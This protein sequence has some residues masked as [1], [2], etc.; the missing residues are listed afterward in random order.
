M[1]GRARSELSGWWH[2]G[3][4]LV[5][6][7]LRVCFRYRVVGIEGVPARGPAILA[8]NHVSALDGPFL[9]LA[10]GRKRKRMTRFLVAAEF[11]EHPQF[12]RALRLLQQIPL[13]R[14]ARDMGALE[15]AERTI[16]AGAL[17]G[18]FPE[19]RVNP[20]PDAGLQRGRRGMAIIALKSRAAIV[21]VG[22]W[23]TQDRWPRDGLHFRRP[24]RPRVALVFGEPI[25]PPG[26][27][28]SR[29]DLNAFTHLVMTRIE[30][31]VE[32]ARAIIRSSR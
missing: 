30:S 12:G 9:A 14:G 3:L 25:E 21:P 32:Q 31:Q 22:I 7:T 20:E 28:A 18:I 15:E 23:G 17:A 2:V 6:A 10:A 26:D 16:R 13:R 24:F 5:G 19:G 4:A 27:A 1:V 8:C 11:F 29:S